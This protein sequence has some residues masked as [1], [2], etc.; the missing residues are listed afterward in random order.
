MSNHQPTS[1]D[2]LVRIEEQR[3]V[4]RM[5]RSAQMAERAAGSMAGGLTSSWANTRPIPVWVE[6]GQGGHIWDVDGN[7][8]VDYH[9]GYGVN[10]VGHANPHVVDA[11]QRRV[12]L[13][14]SMRPAMTRRAGSVAPGCL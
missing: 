10:V 2:D 3:F 4:E 11:V 5:P 14:C 12:A 9:G 7:E 8:Y 6:R 13:G 1:I